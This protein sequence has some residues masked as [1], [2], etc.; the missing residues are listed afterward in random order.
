MTKKDYELLAK[1]L[2]DSSLRVKDR[3]RRHRG[4]GWLGEQEQLDPFLAW[5]EIVQGV[6][7]SLEQDNPRFD[8]NKFMDAVEWGN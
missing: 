5:C 6:M 8:K 3:E 2:S 1:A 4:N 7:N